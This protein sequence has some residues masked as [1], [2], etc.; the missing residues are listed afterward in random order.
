MVRGE[1]GAYSSSRANHKCAGEGKGGGVRAFVWKRHGRGVKIRVRDVEG[2]RNYYYYCCYCEVRGRSSEEMSG[3]G[4]EGGL[5][6]QQ[7]ES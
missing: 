7:S 3:E 1:R 4:E 2:Y 6:Q 5:F